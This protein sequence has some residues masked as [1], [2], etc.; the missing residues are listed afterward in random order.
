MNPHFLYNTL[1]VIG[2]AGL[3]NGNMTVSTMCS[4]LA[5]LLRYSLSYTRQAVLLEQEI[6]NAKSYL[7]IMKMR[8]EEDLIYEWNLD[9]SLNSISVPK[10]ILQPLIENCFQH[11]FQQTEHEILPPWKIRITSFRDDTYWYLSITNNGAPFR[12]EKLIQ[13]QE[14]LQAFKEPEYDENEFEDLVKRQ[15]FGLENT[16]LRL[17][18]YYQGKEFFD[19]ATDDGTEETTVTIGGP[20][21]PQNTFDRF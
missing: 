13:L 3:S 15:G 16:I 5:N 11:G 10:L 20:V 17:N 14:R 4:E 9:E 7:Y 6:T 8:Y 21:M 12:K 1:A 19:V 18:I 2:M